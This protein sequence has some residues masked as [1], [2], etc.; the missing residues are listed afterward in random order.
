MNPFDGQVE[1][2]YQIKWPFSNNMAT[3][4]CL[5]SLRPSSQ[6][7]TAPDTALD[8]MQVS[9]AVARLEKVGL[10]VRRPDPKDLRAKILSLTSTGSA[11]LGKIVPLVQ[12]RE[13]YLLETLTPAERS[14]L[15]S[16]MKA[17]FER[18]GALVSRG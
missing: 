12:A 4:K 2:Y 17:L 1:A 5:I 10:V 8:K 7:K 11:L 14:A 16:A 6:P 15:E 3:L 9:R 13:R 18:A